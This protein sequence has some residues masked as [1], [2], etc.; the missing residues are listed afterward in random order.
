VQRTRVIGFALVLAVS[1]LTITGSSVARS[2]AFKIIVNRNNPAS[3]VT[4]SFLREVF[5]KKTIRWSHGEAVRPIDLPANLPARDRFTTDVL[6]KTPAALRAHWLQCIF[7][8]TGMP[9]PEADSPSS[10]IAYVIA[11]RGAVSYLPLDVD[12]GSAKVIEL[13]E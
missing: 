6:N 2:D 7:S 1:W 9:P 3:A 13:Q 10:A 5:L 11:N 8:G 12:P 4:R